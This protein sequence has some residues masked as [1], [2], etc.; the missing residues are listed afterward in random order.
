M[1]DE[2][3]PVPTRRDLPD[4]MPR[5]AI[6]DAEFPHTPE[7]TDHRRPTLLWVLL[8]ILVAIGFAAVL[9]ALNPPSERIGQ[10]SADV[11]VPSA[12]PIRRP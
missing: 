5:S 8:A 4:E 9:W 7:L 6:S 1:A 3:Q 11:V 2:P 12:P 10:P